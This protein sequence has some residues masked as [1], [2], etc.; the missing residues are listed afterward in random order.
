MGQEHDK[1]PHW[2]ITIDDGFCRQ[3]LTTGPDGAGADSSG[4]I[5]RHYDL[6]SHGSVSEVTNAP[7]LLRLLANSLLDEHRS[8][9]DAVNSALALLDDCSEALKNK[10]IVK[11]LLETN[12][13]FPKTSEDV[14][15]KALRGKLAELA[16]DGEKS[17]SALA[18][19]ISEIDRKVPSVLAVARVTEFVEYFKTKRSIKA[20]FKPPS[21]R[22]ESIAE[23]HIRPFKANAGHRADFEEG[24]SESST[25]KYMIHPSRVPSYF[26]VFKELCG[27]G[28]C[29]EGKV[30]T[31]AAL[32]LIKRA[33]ALFQMGQATIANEKQR[34]EREQGL[35]I[36]P[37]QIKRLASKSVV[38][39]V[40]LVF[41]ITFELAVSGSNW[42][43]W[44]LTGLGVATLGKIWRPLVEAAWAP[45]KRFNLDQSVA[46]KHE[47]DRRTLL[48]EVVL[49]FI[50]SFDDPDT[51]DEF[52]GEGSAASWRAALLGRRDRDMNSASGEEI[53]GE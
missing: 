26:D 23:V 39:A 9:A 25:G 14:D 48:T 2:R 43:A 45:A 15:Y 41:A 32:P 36:A 27:C 34:I 22:D 42:G 3:S 5:D 53:P 24:T 51:W 16:K 12:L 38:P 13:Q 19:C 6:T 33:L 35:S 18:A 10:P 47:F 46:K 37:D 8:F 30:A 52:I 17:V 20:L 31:E 29:N 28:V 11:G 1:R 21:S 49:K 40:G 44:L 4:V 7:N 50:E